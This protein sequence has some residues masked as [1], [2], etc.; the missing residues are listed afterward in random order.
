MAR[1]KLSDVARQQ[2]N[3][4][5]VAMVLAGQTYAEISKK[6][7]LDKGSIS[8]IV[9]N[10]DA[11]NIIKDTQRFYIAMAPAVI[12]RFL[13]CINSDD[14]KIRLQAIK[15]WHRIVGIAPTQTPNV[16]LQQI[17]VDQRKQTIIDPGV[18]Q[19]LGNTVQAIESVEDGDIID[20][21]G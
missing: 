18:M 13:T 20:V 7:G 11:R 15:E 10:S 17:Y 9:N 19:A 14:Q 5:I 6:I 16:F 2:R 4:K 21:E 12:D 1:S 8:R 3:A